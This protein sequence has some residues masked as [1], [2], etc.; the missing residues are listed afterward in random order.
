MCGAVWKSC[1]LSVPL[2]HCT[3][4]RY[5]IPAMN[6]KDCASVILEYIK[7]S[8][9]LEVLL[10][11]LQSWVYFVGTLVIKTWDVFRGWRRVKEL[12]TFP[13]VSG[14]ALH[15]WKSSV[16]FIRNRCRKT[17]VWNWEMHADSVLFSF[18]L[19]STSSLS[20]IRISTIGV[21][22]HVPMK[23]TLDFH[24]WTAKPKRSEMF[25]IFW[26]F[27]PYTQL[28]C[29][30]EGIQNNHVVFLYLFIFLFHFYYSC[31]RS[32]RHKL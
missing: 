1:P 16:F 7:S 30:Y 8:D 19:N 9:M 17:N 31:N 28:L 3:R 6:W 21:A 13:D 22:L 25:S 2:Q 4:Y 24:W 14:L 18:Y 12:T 5:D 26:P 29:I 11:C 20:H 23:I 10:M 27:P 32:P 15:Q